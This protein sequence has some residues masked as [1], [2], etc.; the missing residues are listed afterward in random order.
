MKLV[1]SFKK[2]QTC[3]FLLNVSISTLL[4][5]SPFS[6]LSTG[7]PRF[8]PQGVR[9]LDSEADL[10]PASSAEV[11]S[12]WILTSTSPVRPLQIDK[13]FILLIVLSEHRRVSCGW[14]LFVTRTFSIL[15]LKRLAERNCEK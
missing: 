9:R 10:L 14:C 12:G 11:C 6:L 15:G 8:F 7:Y 3:A 2:T 1:L 4:H 13:I 5:C